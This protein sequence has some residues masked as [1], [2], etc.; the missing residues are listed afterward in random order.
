M[1]KIIKKTQMG[2]KIIEMH[3]RPYLVEKVYN[4]LDNKIIVYSYIMILL[5]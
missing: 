4:N 3:N 2:M 5:K 1:C